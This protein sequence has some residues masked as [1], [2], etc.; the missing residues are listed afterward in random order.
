MTVHFSSK[1][2]EELKKICSICSLWPFC[3]TF[4][5]QHPE[6]HLRRSL[7]PDLNLTADLVQRNHTFLIVSSYIQVFFSLIP[8]LK[9]FSLPLPSDTLKHQDVSRGSLNL[10]SDLVRLRWPFLVLAVEL[11]VGTLS[12]RSLVFR[13]ERVPE[14]IL[15]A[16]RWLLLFW[17]MV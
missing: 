1:F 8:L 9:Y 7:V 10:F 14:I 15:R 12:T 3:I 13:W 2:F 17:S 5:D 11:N 4:K 6:I 16:E